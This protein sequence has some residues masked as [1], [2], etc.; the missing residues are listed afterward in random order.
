MRK[1]TGLL[2]A[3]LGCLYALGVQAGQSDEMGAKAIFFKG[4]D[5]YDVQAAPEV[6]ATSVEKKAILEPEKKSTTSVKNDT[7]IVNKPKPKSK[8]AKPVLGVQAWVKRVYS[9]GETEIVSPRSQ[10]FKAGDKIRL[11]FKTNV[12]GYLY[13]VNVGTSGR[14]NLLFPR[15]G[16][17]NLV[18]AHQELEI[19]QTLVFDG[20]PGTEQLA[21]IVSKTQLDTASIPLADGTMTVD[22][23]KG[24]SAPLQMVRQGAVKTNSASEKN[25][26][27]ALADLSGSKDLKFEDDG[28]MVTVVLHEPEVVLSPVASNTPKVSG[29]KPLVANLQLRHQ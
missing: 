13:V 1:V 7:K 26:S 6:S 14:V 17:S 4:A 8:T 16:S 22:L 27:L 25:A 20:N 15:N 18:P 5:A 2:A 29:P 24:S 10:V 11:G 19:A 12:T 9:S 3:S 21:V 23:T 28:Q